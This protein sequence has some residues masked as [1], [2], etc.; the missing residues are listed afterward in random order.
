[1]KGYERNY[2]RAH[3]GHRVKINELPQ[4]QFLRDSTGQDPMDSVISVVNILFI[5][6]GR[7]VF[8]TK[9]SVTIIDIKESTEYF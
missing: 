9:H 7:Q 8:L 6:L 5:F 3:R 4:N 2:H 1:M